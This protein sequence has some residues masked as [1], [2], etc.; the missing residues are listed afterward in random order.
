MRS[1]GGLTLLLVQSASSCM[2]HLAYLAHGTALPT[3]YYYL[4][5]P[6][7]YSHKQ[8]EFKLFH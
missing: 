5:K 3:K 6:E 2:T 1:G 8:W 7:F 4:M